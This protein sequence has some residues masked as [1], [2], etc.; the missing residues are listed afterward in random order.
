MYNLLNQTKAIMQEF[1]NIILMGKHKNYD[2]GGIVQKVGNY[3]SALQYNIFLDSETKENTTLDY[4]VAVESEKY[5]LV[6]VIGGDGTMI[7]AARKWGI[8]GIPL[9]GINQGRV[10][11][12]TDI[13]SDDVFE[14]ISEI[15]SGK[16]KREERNILNVSVISNGKKVVYNDIAIND[17]VCRSATGKLMEFSLFLNDEFISSQHADGIIVA[18][19]TGSTAYSLAA[20]GSIIHPDSEVLNIVPIC[21]QSLSN[22]PLVVSIHKQIK[23]LFSG[24]EGVKYTADGKDSPEITT[25]HYFLI[26][27]NEKKIQLIHPSSYSYFEGLRK[28]LKWC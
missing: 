27:N 4:P 13:S 21:P 14:G 19:S 9:L 12:L 11:F 23:I 5:D 10:G 18:T 15:L 16:F 7:G 22:R 2:L 24:K 6:I 17:L 26:K 25:G 28:K 1:K 20:G 8:L 3:L